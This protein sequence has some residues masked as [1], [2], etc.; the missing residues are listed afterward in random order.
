MGY[1]YLRFGIQKVPRDRGI[2][3][4]GNHS[5]ITESIGEDIL[6]KNVDFGVIDYFEKVTDKDGALATR[7]LAKKEGLFLDTAAAQPS[8]ACVSLRTSLPLTMWWLCFSTTGSRYVGKV[9][10]DDWMRD[11]DSSPRQQSRERPH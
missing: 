6:P 4:K 8:K 10:N 11:G 2:R 7:E 3:R 9:Y 1:R 5:Y